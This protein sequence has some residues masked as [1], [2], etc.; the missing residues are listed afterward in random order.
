[1]SQLSFKPGDETWHKIRRL[2]TVSV[3][4]KHSALYYL[5]SVVLGMGPL[6]PMTYR[7]HLAMCLFAEGATGIPE[8]DQARVKMVL[9]PRGCGKSS[10]LTKGLSLLHLL[11]QDDW[12]VGIANEIE[13]NAIAFLGSIKA[14]FESNDLLRALWPERIPD[15]ATTT[16]RSD[17]IV[18]KRAKPN[19]VS[20]S[21]LATGVGGTVTGKHMK[22]W[23]LDDLLS[24]NAAEAAYRGNFEEIEKV[25]RWIKRL[26]PLLQSPER[27][28]I[29][30]FGTRWWA[31]DTYEFCEKFFGGLPESVDLREIPPDFECIW[32]LTIPPQVVSWDY[33]RDGK[34][35]RVEIPGEVQHIRLYRRGD[36]AVFKRAAIDENGRSIFPERYTLEELEQIQRR[37]P[38]FF[39]GQYMLEPTAGGASAFQTAWLK[40][41]EWDGPNFLRFQDNA[42]NTHTIAIR[43][44]AIFVSVDPAFSDKHSSARS[45]IPV[46]G[47]NG[48]EIFLLEDFA[49]KFGVDDIANKVCD[50][51]LRYPV[52][53]IFVETIVAQVAVAD[54]IR[55]IARERGISLPPIEE[56]RSHGQQKKEW[57]I[58]G[59]E[60]YF[61]K[62]IFYYHKSH[63]R[64]L[65][66]YASFPLGALRD[67]LDALAFQREEW[68]RAARFASGAA[69]LSEAKRLAA[70]QAAIARVRKA[71]GPRRRLG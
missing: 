67:I 25:N 22:S 65:G 51:C 54:A 37:D 27:D 62:G 43:D 4:G 21:V 47:T 6:V 28:P 63:T 55:R 8:I 45:A 41:Y 12:S 56:I 17:E 68:E 61:R 40:T 13:D 39:A 34:A 38:V 46:V 42:G 71:W 1:M 30:I 59:L 70:E 35:E 29:Y 14:E 69:G 26:P 49:D 44:L 5:N 2:C 64:F 18:I 36:I 58:Y 9:V 52:R 23:V 20:P 53:K 15:F 57:R 60:P 66:E 33:D 32:S 3:P 16:W 11:S 19:P 50:F 31:G 7:A 48:R 10:L 24:Q